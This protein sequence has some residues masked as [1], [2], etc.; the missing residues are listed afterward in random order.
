M[1]PKSV[2][3]T[4]TAS[5]SAKRIDGTETLRRELTESIRELQ[6]PLDGLEARLL[7]QGVKVRFDF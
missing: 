4:P 1:A 5:I 3:Y 6:L 7:A 2:V